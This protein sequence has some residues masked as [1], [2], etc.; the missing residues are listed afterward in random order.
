MPYLIIMAALAA[1][2]LTRLYLQHRRES[3]RVQA[4][5]GFLDSLEAISSSPAGPERPAVPQRDL[6]SR[7]RPQ[8]APT[9]RGRE[10]SLDPERRAAAR[11]RIEQR[12]KARSRLAG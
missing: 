4:V 7:R 9:R 12:R 8:P 11:R 1:A 6:Q 2:A 5:D 3:V 10:V